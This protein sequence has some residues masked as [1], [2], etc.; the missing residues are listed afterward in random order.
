MEAEYDGVEKRLLQ[1]GQYAMFA[2]RDV[3]PGA[4]LS[5]LPTGEL[6]STPDRYTIQVGAEAHLVHERGAWSMYLNHHCD[7]NVVLRFS[8]EKVASNDRGQ[9]VRVPVSVHLVAARDIQLGEELTFNYLS[10]EWDMAEAFT[11]SCQSPLCFKSI[12]GFSKLDANQKERLASVA[13][14]FIASGA[15]Q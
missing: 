12:A 9:R 4:V 8:G 13:T 15:A 7:P 11:C 14:P 10:S 2:T 1:N 6:K 3:E 5:S